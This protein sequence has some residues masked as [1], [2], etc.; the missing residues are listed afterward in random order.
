[1]K[2]SLVLITFVLVL[3]IASTA[4]LAQEQINFSDLPSVATPTPMPLGYQGMNWANLYY[5]NPGLYSSS[6]PGYLNLL[7]HKDV[8]FVG[9]QF[10][11]PVGPGCF[12][13]ISSPGGPTAFQV[14]SAVMVAGYSENNVS[15]SAYDR[16]TYKGTMNF[17]LTANPQLVHFPTSWGTITELQIETN[18]AGNLV[19]WGL[20]VYRIG[21]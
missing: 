14:I 7:T 3:A 9:G 5:V 2:R 16:G 15:V 21:G 4:A 1:M 11:G 8:V 10:C 12:G 6:G 17:V 19:L 13:I 18:R 20:S